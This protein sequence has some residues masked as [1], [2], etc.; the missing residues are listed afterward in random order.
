[1]P[2]SLENRLPA[3]LPLKARRPWGFLLFCAWV[4]EAQSARL[5]APAGHLLEACKAMA[6][7]NEL[8]KTNGAR[9][10]IFAQQQPFDLLHTIYA[11]TKGVVEDMEVGKRHLC[12]HM[13]KDCDWL[14]NP[15]FYANWYD[16][17]LNKLFKK[18]LRTVSHGTFE[19]FVL[20]RMRDGLQSEAVRK[21]KAD[22]ARLGL[23]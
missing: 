11:R 1:M 6:V 22:E 2:R 7:F 18:F 23:G 10:P 4:L 3:I 12:V 21:R 16:E 9:M 19:P 17:S 5:P 8:F 20:L 13:V 15:A 14:G